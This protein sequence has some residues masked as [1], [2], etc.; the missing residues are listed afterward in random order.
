M[1]AGRHV[2]ISVLAVFLQ[3][4]N[5]LEMIRD[6]NVKNVNVNVNSCAGQW[7]LYYHW[8]LIYK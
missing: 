7:F 6:L 2:L 8:F 1:Y 3:T 4:I 5:L